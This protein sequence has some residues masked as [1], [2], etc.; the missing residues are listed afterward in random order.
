M[1]CIAMG[2]E[3]L[4]P[5]DKFFMPEEKVLHGH[6]K[7]LSIDGKSLLDMVNFGTLMTGH[8]ARS[9]DPSLHENAST[10]RVGECA[11]RPA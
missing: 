4:T 6:G 3:A 1:N 5:K 8:Y 7:V 2:E 10:Q 9:G 11:G